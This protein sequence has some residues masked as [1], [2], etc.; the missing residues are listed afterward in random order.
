MLKKPYLKVQILQYKFL[1]W[2]WPPPP[3]GTFPKIHPIWKRDPSLRQGPRSSQYQNSYLDL[4]V[5]GVHKYLSSHIVRSERAS[6]LIWEKGRT[7]PGVN[8]VTYR[9]CL[10]CQIGECAC[11]QCHSKYRPDSLTSLLFPS[12]GLPRHD[13]VSSDRSSRRDLWPLRFVC[14]RVR[15]GKKRHQGTNKAFLGVGC[16]YLTFNQWLNRIE[17]KLAVLYLN[18]MQ[19]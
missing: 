6:C 16:L 5:F 3:F 17:R 13:Y 14:V 1:D 19:T 8:L 9:L 12:E 7:Q 15:W 4:A 2:K 18:T 11:H 10:I